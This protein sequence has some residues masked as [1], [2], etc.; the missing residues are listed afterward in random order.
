MSPK[1]LTRRFNFIGRKELVHLIAVYGPSIVGEKLH[2]LD[3]ILATRQLICNYL[4]IVGGDFNLIRSLK[5]KK[6]SVHKLYPKVASFGSYIEKLP[7]VDISIINGL[8]NWNNQW[9]GRHKIFSWLDHFILSKEVMDN[10]IFV[11]TVILPCLG[12]DHYLVRIELDPLK[13]L[14]GYL[15]WLGDFFINKGL[16]MHCE[17]FILKK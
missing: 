10:D 11:E 12:L 3:K 15:F 13:K 9:G 1:I 2:F 16:N 7:L 6:G 17:I 5:D 8:Y 14:W 4:W